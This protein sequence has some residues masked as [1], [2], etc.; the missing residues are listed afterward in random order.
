MTFFGG[1]G[2]YYFFI[3]FVKLK[4]IYVRREEVKIQ[5]L[6]DQRR[7]SLGQG[8]SWPPK[9]KG[10]AVEFRGIAVVAA[11]Q[12]RRSLG[13]GRA[14]RCHGSVP[15]M[16]WEASSSAGGGCGGLPEEE[17]KSYREGWRRRLSSSSLNLDD[18]R[19]RLVHTKLLS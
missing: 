3:K 4:N 5:V 9:T 11:D 6:K 18:P 10:M 19:A 16:C 14:A 8:K 7:R 2:D 13:Q 15:A 1:R 17:M 12:R